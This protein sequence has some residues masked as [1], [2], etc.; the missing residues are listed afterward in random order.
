MC[1]LGSPPEDEPVRI[2]I[3]AA[4]FISTHG[5]RALLRLLFGLEARGCDGT[6]P[7]L[8]G[9][10]WPLIP[11]NVKVSASIRPF[12]GRLPII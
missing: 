6:K 7:F 1:V 5:V 10:R 3:L 4:G 8:R 12:G 9:E 11:P 2:Q